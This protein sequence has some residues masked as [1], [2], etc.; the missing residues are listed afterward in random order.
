MNTDLF[1]YTLQLIQ[2]CSSDRVVS[3]VTVVW[4]EGP[5]FRILAGRKDVSPNHPKWLPRALF[6]REVRS[7]RKIEA[8]IHL[9]LAPRLKTSVAV[10]TFVLHEEF[11]GGKFTFLY[12]P[13]FEATFPELPTPSLNYKYINK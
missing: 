7:G 6:P 11:I 3:I 9:H 2:L 5:R 4:A 1:P 8:V 10:T 12:H 13:N